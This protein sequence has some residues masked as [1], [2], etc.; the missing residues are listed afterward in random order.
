M[1]DRRS[2]PPPETE[3]ERA[4]R[5]VK[6]LKDFITP[7]REKALMAVMPKGMTVKRIV[8]ILCSAVS[9]SPLLTRCTVPSLYMGF[10]QAT[11]LGL[12]IDI[13]GQAYLVPFKNNQTG[14]YEAALIVG[15]QGYCKLLYQSGMVR[16]I[17]CRVVFEKDEFDYRYG[18]KPDL[19]H[20][21]SREADP[22]KPVAAY[23]VV[24]LENGEVPFEVMTEPELMKV[25]ASS[26]AKG[27]PWEKWP[28]EMRRK[29]P[30]RRQQK[31][32]PKSIDD[33][34][35]MLHRANL[36]E[37]KAEAG[38]QAIVGIEG[39]L[40]EECADADYT[41]LDPGQPMDKTE[42]VTDI[43]EERHAAM[44]EGASPEGDVP[45]ETIEVSTPAPD[46]EEEWKKD[47]NLYIMK[48]SGQ[49]TD[50]KEWLT[51]RGFEWGVPAGHGKVY[52]LQD[53]PRIN[54]ERI[55][56]DMLKLK[57]HPNDPMTVMDKLELR[58]VVEN[59]ETGDK[60]IY[61]TKA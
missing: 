17:D 24:W 60:L 13:G 14:H 28:N 38:E 53:Q 31:F 9:R 58:L 16:R 18:L 5:H 20:I 6:T 27:G 42:E 59:Q 26:R 35:L 19:V 49:T 15:Y 56:A 34:T 25:K 47:P 29:C 52:F 8:P 37:E 57:R 44:Q 7:S 3:K 41:V 11:A 36:I 50:W 33:R 2:L 55:R 51:S 4:A 61:G 23:S 21:P 54:V 22:G 32:L 48:V 43:L 10:A 1:D 45:R 30:I 40:P 39:D 12:E 46:P